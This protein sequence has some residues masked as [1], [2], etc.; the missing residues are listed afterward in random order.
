MEG[1]PCRIHR[2]L[3]SSD[4]KY[5]LPTVM[6]FAVAREETA[7]L[8]LSLIFQLRCISSITP[9]VFCVIILKSVLVEG[10]D[11]KL[12][13]EPTGGLVSIKA[14]VASESEVSLV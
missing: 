3:L 8:A 4:G 7:P 13:A 5:V 14:G 11:Q 12:A 6:V 2:L 9:V 1:K 10:P